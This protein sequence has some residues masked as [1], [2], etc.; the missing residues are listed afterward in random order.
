MMTWGVRICIY[1]WGGTMFVKNRIKS[2]IEKKMM[3]VVRCWELQFVAIS[4]PQ[5]ELSPL[6]EIGCN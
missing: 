4:L 3:E 2:E 6:R 5:Q 1:L